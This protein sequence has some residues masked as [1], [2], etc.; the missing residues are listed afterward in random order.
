MPTSLI[1]FINIR[2][3]PV[4]IDTGGFAITWHGLFTAIGIAAGVWLAIRLAQL[5]RLNED[6]SM[7]IAVVSVV[8]GIVGARLLWVF[9]HTDQIHSVGDVFAVTD[10]GISVYGAMIGGVLGGIHLRLDLQALVSQVGRARCR[11]AGDDSGPGDRP[12]R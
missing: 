11:R 10:G 6:D 12:A 4:L 5:A 8:F 9:E 3:N 7:S 1:A 2:I